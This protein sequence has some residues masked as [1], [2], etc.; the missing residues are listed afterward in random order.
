MTEAVRLFLKPAEDI[1][2]ITTRAWTFQESLPS[3]RS[4]LFGLSDRSPSLVG[5]SI[6]GR[7]DGSLTML[8]KDG[9]FGEFGEFS[10]RDGLAPNIHAMNR[11]KDN[12]EKTQ[13]IYQ[14]WCHAINSYTRRK[15]SRRNDKFAAIAGYARL[16]QQVT[17]SRY[18]YG[19]WEN[20]LACGLM[21][22]A[23][24][25][26]K[27]M[28]NLLLVLSWSWASVDSKIWTVSPLLS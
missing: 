21:W 24:P 2:P 27:P 13:Y 16:F 20:D 8:P 18:M 14:S 12:Q 25:N 15:M 9:T 5:N 23:L 19:L 4:L 17:K 26:I 11:Y 22:T 28:R 1:G 3:Q 6:F 7:M 10:T